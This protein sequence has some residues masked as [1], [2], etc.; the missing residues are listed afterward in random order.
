MKLHREHF[1]VGDEYDNFSD[2]IKRVSHV[3]VERD[4][5]TD[6]FAEA[7]IRREQEYPTGI[8]GDMNFAIPHADIGHVTTSTFAIIIPSNKI[9]VFNMIDSEESIEPEIIILFA[10]DEGIEHINFLQRTMQLFQMTSELKH[11]LLMSVDDQF[12]FFEKFYEEGA[13]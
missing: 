11:M 12:K 1:F 7:V 10:L 4:F 5:V 2:M 3:L 13:E 9:E 6:G 8:K